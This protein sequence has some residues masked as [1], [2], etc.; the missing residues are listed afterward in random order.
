MTD[1]KQKPVPLVIEG[2]GEL[3]VLEY[4]RQNAD[5][6]DCI[7]LYA[8]DAL[9][10]EAALGWADWD[11]GISLSAWGIVS[12]A[13]KNRMQ[14]LGCPDDAPVVDDPYWRSD[15]QCQAVNG[16]GNG[17]FR[18]ID[19]DGGQNIRDF[20]PPNSVREI[21]GWTALQGYPSGYALSYV[22]S[23]GDETTIKIYTTEGLFYAWIEP[24]QNDWCVNTQ[25]EY[26]PA[27]GDPIGPPIQVGNEECVWTVTPV[28]SYVDQRGMYWIKYSVDPDPSTCGRAF[29]YWNSQTGV[30]VCD[31]DDWACPP[32][33]Q[34]TG[35]GT[36]APLLNG[37]TYWL[38]PPCED[39]EEWGLEEGEYPELE[40]PIETANAWEG[41]AKRIDA[42]AEMLDWH[43]TCRT[44]ICP[45]VSTKEGE[46]RTISFRSD[47]VS[48]YGSGRLR[49]RFR[50]RS[51]SGIGLGDLVDHWRDF[52]FQAGP[53]IV[54]HLGAS[55][56]T[57]K[58]WAATADEGKRVIR[59]AAGEAGIDPDKDGRWSISGSDS[60]RL[61]VPGTMRVDTK[62]GYYWITAR[63]GS[64][65][66]PIVAKTRSDL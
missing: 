38:Y 2:L 28:D 3:S 9:G 51:T 42:V 46:F 59:H 7:E 4:I 17:K 6:W 37:V 54:Q 12:Q 22:T 1:E 61:G 49:K 11:K 58:V 34:R 50:Y 16:A 8:T 44:P 63:D 29:F 45:N 26:T 21:I 13:I 10:Y 41:I 23:S 60:A 65:H 18:T 62:G 43:L 15:Q 47:D 56:G 53:V 40:F 5:R 36:E 48:P 52:T 57:P 24:N 14:F 32:P 31:P 25:R 35:G 39:P 27:D 19:A 55:W 20:G 30:K 33:D 66:R 64:D